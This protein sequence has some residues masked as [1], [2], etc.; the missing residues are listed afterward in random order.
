M[1]YTRKMKLPFLLVKIIF[2]MASLVTIYSYWYEARGSLVNAKKELK[3]KMVSSLKED[4]GK[5]VKSFQVN[6]KTDVI[7]KLIGINRNTILDLTTISC[8]EVRELNAVSFFIQD[9]EYKKFILKSGQN[10]PPFKFFLQDDGTVKLTE[11]EIFLFSNNGKTLETFPL[12]YFRKGE[13]IIKAINY[14]GR[15][16]HGLHCD[17]EQIKSTERFN[18]LGRFL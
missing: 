11:S 6:Y 2:L 9:G 5:K 17:L 4:L 14:Y 15:P 1:V 3:H 13:D 7:D 10:F 18:S 16:M 8:D 12:E